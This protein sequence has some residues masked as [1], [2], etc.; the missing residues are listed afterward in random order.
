MVARSSLGPDVVIAGAARSG[1]S[2]L[3]AQLSEHPGIDPGKVKE[4]NYFSRHL[5][6]GERWYESNFA[7]RSDGML[8]LDASTSYTSPLYPQALQHLAATSP[9]A[10]VIFSVRQPTERALSHYLLRR[11]YFSIDDAPTFGAALHGSSLYV[12]H[13]DYSHWLPLLSDMFGSDRLLVVPFELVTAQPRQA[14]EEICRRLGL[15]PP[16]DAAKEAE[17]HR[18]SVVEY[19]N[20]RVRRMASTFRR[21]RAYPAVR[22]LVGAG[23]LRKARGLVT[24]APSLPT[25]DESMQSCSPEQLAELQALDERAGEATRRYL[26][27]QDARLEL[28]WAPLS[29]AAAVA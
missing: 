5:D 21:S 10:Y 22:S 9:G 29:F 27:A 26:E 23:Q 3:A 20:E 2:A 17:R 16:P 24:R 25:T 4:P 13:S 6:R 18:N 12:D 19:R 14:T 28:R 11:H 8:R 7:S 15:E 1:T